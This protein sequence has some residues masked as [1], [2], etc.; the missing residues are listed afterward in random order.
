MAN[1]Q[2]SSA[3]PPHP[4]P[5][6]HSVSRA[7]LWFGLLAAPL[8]WAIDELVLYYVASHLCELK[9]HDL[10]GTLARGTSPWFI[11]VSVAALLVAL[12]GVWVS[13]GSW[14]K[15][16]R[17]KGGSEAK[18][19][20]VGEGRTRFLAMCGLLTSVGFLIGFLFIFSQLW[21]APLC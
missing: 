20:E 13:Y 9:T 14:H 5:E 8:A 21:V 11:G 10:A 7:A 15:S 6:R 3:S 2:S 1:P 18:L 17:E 19:I 16:Q 4:A 12:A